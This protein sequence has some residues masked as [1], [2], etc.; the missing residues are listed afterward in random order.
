MRN[1]ELTIEQ[2]K[3]VLA[4]V[5]SQK[6]RW[7]QQ[8]DGSEIGL[9]ALMD[10]LVVLAKHDNQSYMDLKEDLTKANRQL[11]AANARETKLK[12]EL[13]EAKNGK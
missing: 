11:A 6:E 3:D 8:Y 4:H 2:A 13:E 9:S 5:V 7:G 12:R 1:R 10:A